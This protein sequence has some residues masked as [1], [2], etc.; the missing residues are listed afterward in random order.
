[1]S[2]GI[3]V[4][5][6]QRVLLSGDNKADFLTYLRRSGAYQNFMF[7]MVQIAALI[8]QF[9]LDMCDKNTLYNLQ[10]FVEQIFVYLTTEV[11][12]VLHKLTNLGRTLVKPP[13]TSLNALLFY[14]KEATEMRN[15]DLAERYYLEVFNY[16][17]V[18]FSRHKVLFLLRCH[19]EHFVTPKTISQRSIL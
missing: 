2:W 6:S 13:K 14:A 9:R 4:V 5:S 3:S 19:S 7:G 17:F 10:N 8:S 1:V 11:N 15:L 18:Y 12:Q 16:Q